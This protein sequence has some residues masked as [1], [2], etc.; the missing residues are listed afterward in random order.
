[1]QIHVVEPNETLNSIASRYN[2]SPAIIAEANQLPNRDQLVVG[3]ALV[4]PILGSFY[5]VQPGDSLWAIAQKFGISYQELARINGIHVNQPIQVGLRLYIPQRA[6]RDGEFLAYVEP[7]RVGEVS[8]QLESSAREA[9]PY[10]TYLAPFSY[11]PKRD[12]SLDPP[13]LNRFPDIAKA[14]NTALAMVL[15][16][17]EE[18]QFNTELVHILLTDEKV[19]TTFLNNILAEA[20]RVGFT[21]I[22]FDFERIAGE[23]REA[24]NNFLRR[25]KDLF[26]REGFII[27]TALAP[28]TSATQ[29]GEWYEGHDY[30][31]HGEIVDYT[32]IMTYE[33][34]YSGGP[35][36]A[37][38]P[39][40][41]VRD[42]LEYAITEIPPEKIM[43]GQNLYGY[44]WTL[45][46]VQG[47]TATAVSP[48][49]A[50][51]IA[52]ENNAAI[53]YDTKAQAPFFHY[54]DQDGKEHEVWFEDARSIQAKFNL[55]KELGIRGVG[56]WKLG[57]P[58]PQNWLLITD[59][60]N[61]KKNI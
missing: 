42:V 14:N 5:W 49:R 52:A 34:G 31:A 27:S 50:I 18:G 19:Q 35:A 55:V 6:K 61:V 48:Q 37:V 29:K 1:M 54:T 45:P 53:E 56:Y 3:Q 46:F 25:A 60:F 21:D 22:H 8:P 47:T 7:R 33:W 40:N 9:S 59:N 51:Q 23:D 41:S 28:K 10:L 38:S 11:F 4:I 16:N 39:I 43:M 58:F 17:Q 26:H 15:A 30:K 44:D 12:G 24:Y 13:N 57:L 32:L 36:M 2:I 20:K